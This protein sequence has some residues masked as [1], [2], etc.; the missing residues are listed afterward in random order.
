MRGGMFPRI[1]IVAV[2]GEQTRDIGEK[3][4]PCRTNEGMHKRITFRS[5][6]VVMPLILVQKV[7]SVG[8]VVVLDDRNPDLKHQ[9]STRSRQHRQPE[10]RKVDTSAPMEIGTATTDDNEDSREKETS[11][12]WTLRCKLSTKE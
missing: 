8:N 5:A 3:T 7:V 4:L 11:E 2:N 10:R 12:S 6:S 1:K 9:S